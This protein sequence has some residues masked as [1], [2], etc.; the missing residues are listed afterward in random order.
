MRK[1]S[2]VALS[3]I[4]ALTACNNDGGSLKKERMDWNIKSFHQER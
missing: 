1:L 3:A 4:L 2:Y